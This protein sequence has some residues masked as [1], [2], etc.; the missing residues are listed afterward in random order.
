[1]DFPCAC[2]IS[3]PNEASVPWHWHEELEFVC[4]Y[5]GSFVYEVGGQRFELEAGEAAFANS[6]VPHAEWSHD[7]QSLEYDLVCH[8]RLL[9]GTKSSALYTRYFEPLVASSRVSGVAL[10][11]Y[12][13]WQEEAARCVHRA[14]EAIRAND[15]FFEETVREQLTHACLLISK[16]QGEIEAAAPVPPAGN[17]RVELM[18][19]YLKNHYVERVPMAALAAQAGIS[20]RQAQ[21]EFREALGETPIA[22]LTAYRLQVAAGMLTNTNEPLAIIAASCG[23]QSPSYFSKMFRERYGCTPSEYRQRI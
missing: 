6:G 7:P 3:R 10:R 12:G 22:Y 1:M 23:F 8:P 18:C 15:E 9:Y 2:Y 20:V 5:E 19:T 4:A 17:E 16:H 14:I 13:G 21:R 11:C